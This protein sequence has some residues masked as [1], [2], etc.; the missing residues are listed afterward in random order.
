MVAVRWRRARSRARARRPAIRS[1]P[2]LERARTT[3]GDRR[4][5]RYDRSTGRPRARG[6]SS[7]P[8]RAWCA[9]IGPRLGGPAA[10]GIDRV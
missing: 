10:G 3:T 6:P 7:P 5:D 4:R 8:G 9:R 1:R 2:T